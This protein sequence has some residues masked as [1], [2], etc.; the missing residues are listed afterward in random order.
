MSARHRRFLQF[1]N[2]KLLLYK[3]SVV[4]SLLRACFAPFA[5][6]S[7]ARAVDDT[8]C[9]ACCYCQCLP[10]VVGWGRAQEACR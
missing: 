7:V 3:M 8:E 9:E 4:A 10:C 2:A 6:L 5:S 1:F